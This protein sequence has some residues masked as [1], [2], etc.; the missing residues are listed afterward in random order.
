[1][2]ALTAPGGSSKERLLVKTA[3]FAPESSY[4][5]VLAKRSALRNQRREGV[6]GRVRSDH[7]AGAARHGRSA[8]DLRRVRKRDSAG[9]DQGWPGPGKPERQEVG[10]SGNCSPTC[11]G[12]PEATPLRSQQ[13]R[14]RPA[15]AD[16]PHLRS[17]DSGL[18]YFPEE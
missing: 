10:P 12:N 1:M 6:E 2:H 7:R 9:T 17:P 16:R 3:H 13:I 11:Y 18:T 8:R 15:A 14:N 4:G 5:S